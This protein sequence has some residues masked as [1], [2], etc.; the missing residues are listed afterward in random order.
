MDTYYSIE[1]MFHVQTMRTGKFS[2]YYYYI[3]QQKDVLSYFSHKLID[4]VISY[5][6]NYNME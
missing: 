5:Y 4:K 3:I 1:Q 2:G 6:M